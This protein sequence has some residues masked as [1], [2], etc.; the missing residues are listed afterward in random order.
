VVTP[1]ASGLEDD[2]DED[3]F[4]TTRK[5]LI[6]NLTR[7]EVTPSV[8]PSMIEQGYQTSVRRRHGAS[9]RD[10]RDGYLDG[11]IAMKRAL[12]V[13]ELADNGPPATD[14]PI[15]EAH[16]VQVKDASRVME[17]PVKLSVPV[18]DCAIVRLA[19]HRFGQQGN[20]IVI[21]TPD[22]VERIDLYLNDAQLQAL[23]VRGGRRLG[24]E[25]T[26]LAP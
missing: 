22:G 26:M 24:I 20:L 16:G 7:R 18:N 17:R 9:R 8:T 3:I 11:A 21:E 5:A 10:Y 2:D 14:S 25:T 1:P 12:E 13:T 19:P 6:E 15:A 23:V 4:A